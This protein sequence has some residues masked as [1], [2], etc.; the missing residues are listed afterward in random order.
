MPPPDFAG[1]NVAGAKLFMGKFNES[2]ASFEK[3]VAVRDV[4]YIRELQ[5]LLGYNYL[6]MSLAWNAHTL[7]CLGYPDFALKS[8]E[9]AIEFAREFVQPFNQ[10]IAITYR[11][12]MSDWY[13]EPSEFAARALEAYQQAI[14]CR[15]PYYSAWSNILV[16]FG[17]TMQ[18]PDTS[19]LA[20]LRSAIDDFAKTGARVRLPLYFCLLARACHRAGQIE[21][22]QEALEKAFLASEQNNEHWWDAELHRLRGELWLAQGMEADK[23]EAFFFVRLKLPDPNRHDPLSCAPRAAW[24]DCGRNKGNTLKPVVCYRPFT[25]GLQ[26]DSIR[27]T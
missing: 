26:K 6:V 11:A 19:N 10:S 15:A 14:E 24:H 1:I 22:A 21:P 20:R 7:W 8:A 18:Q 2:R 5:G 12:L 9:T 27:R 17:E 4:E 13:A 23:V 25:V 16:R 3:I